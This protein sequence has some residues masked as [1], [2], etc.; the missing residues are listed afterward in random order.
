MRRSAYPLADDREASLLLPRW[1]GQRIAEVLLPGHHN[2]ALFAL[3]ESVVDQWTL[4][5]LFVH[6]HFSQI[7]QDRAGQNQSGADNSS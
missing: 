5:S 2:V 3:L 7:L 4:L 6:L 1:L